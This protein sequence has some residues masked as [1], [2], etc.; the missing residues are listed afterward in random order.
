[1]ATYQKCP[2]AVYKVMNELVA[3]FEGHNSIAEASV[4]IDLLFAYG[5]RDPDTQELVSDAIKHD[6]VKALGKARKLSLKDR[7]AGRGDAEILLDGDFWDS[8]SEDERRAVLDHELYHIRVK[9]TRS[10]TPQYD[11]LRRPL[12]VLRKHDFQFGWFVCMAKRHGMASIECIQAE[13]ILRKAGEE[14]FPG[15]AFDVKVREAS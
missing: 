1:M 3:D 7:A 11:D 15:F 14:L 13:Q 6:G 8:A 4:K 12:L 5:D 10:G 9:T 2:A